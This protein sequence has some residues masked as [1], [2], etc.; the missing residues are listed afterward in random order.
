MDFQQFAV[1]LGDAG[2][3]GHWEGVE[4]GISPDK[5]PKEKVQFIGPNTVDNTIF[6]LVS[7]ASGAASAAF[8]ETPREQI[9]YG[10]L[11]A[12]GSGT[13]Y[14]AL[15]AAI[16]YMTGGKLTRLNEKLTNKLGFIDK[17]NKFMAERFPNKYSYQE[18]TEVYTPNKEMF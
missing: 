3:M 14:A 8:G 18:T 17:L 13:V 16:D 12:V 2:L 6:G 10:A 1:A 5:E 4:S 15:H 11:G 9:G 7:V